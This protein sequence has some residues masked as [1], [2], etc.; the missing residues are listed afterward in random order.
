MQDLAPN[1]LFL[2]AQINFLK[3]IP[4]K[5]YDYIFTNPPF[6][7]RERENAG[8]LE[9]VW[10]FDFIQR[11]YA[12]L[13]EGGELIGI[14]GNHWMKD[15]K[16]KKWYQEHGAIIETKKGETFKPLEG[17]AIKYNVDIIK[18]K[19]LKPLY[20]NEDSDI[21]KRGF[22]YQKDPE[23][24]ALI[25]NNDVAIA[26][27]IEPPKK[28]NPEVVVK[29]QPDPELE[30]PPELLDIPKKSIKL[31]MKDNER[32]DFSGCG[33]IWQFL[34]YNRKGETDMT[35][36]LIEIAKDKEDKR[37]TYYIM[38]ADLEQDEVNIYENFISIKKVIN[39]QF[40]IA[41]KKS[42]ET[43]H[44]SA[45]ADIGG[46]GQRYELN[47]YKDEDNF[48][49]TI[50]NGKDQKLYFKQLFN[51]YIKPSKK[52][53][54]EPE[55]EPEPEPLTD[56]KK[57]T[58][59][60]FFS[61][62][63]KIISNKN[64]IKQLDTEINKLEK[65]WGDVMKKYN[66]I[67]IE[68]LNKEIE[69]EYKTVDLKPFYKLKGKPTY[70]DIAMTNTMYKQQGIKFNP[71]NKGKNKTDIKDKFLSLNPDIKIIDEK[72]FE[73]HMKNFRNNVSKEKDELEEKQRD[74]FRLIKDKERE[75]KHYTNLLEDPNYR[76]KQ[77][78]K[79]LKEEK[80]FNKKLQEQYGTKFK[81]ITIHSL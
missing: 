66:S 22:Y 23:L 4:S 74:L 59:E 67:K 50:K 45:P 69:K 58:L 3:F 14:T 49:K 57:K 48:I 43:F 26:D 56:K 73:E 81:G 35:P 8:L 44:L 11:A 47:I 7:L 41:G 64:K 16:Q 60:K 51:D 6:H 12:M 37:I 32:Y 10:D 46:A 33:V 68:D 52:Q 53:K 77:Q 21:L 31:Q 78:L 28:P 79:N 71:V 55:P 29:P 17:R 80:E 25:N 65:E 54:P 1:S 42:R 38:G 63:S 30:I 20:P 34:K 76:E 2:Q 18:L 24:G 39:S 15:E 13:K 61:K 75:K 62:S 36:E 72:L 9:D 70:D 5:R 40:T 19:K 27:I